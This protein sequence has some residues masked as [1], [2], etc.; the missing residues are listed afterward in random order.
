M[1]FWSTLTNEV[2]ALREA[3]ED[4]EDEENQS[5]EPSPPAAAATDA[6]THADLLM[7]PPASIYVMPGALSELI[8]EMK[9]ELYRIYFA[10]IDPVFKVLHKPS[11]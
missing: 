5:F 9:S 1:P 11:M 6:V 10:N 3:L 2:Q 4:D 7:I 8:G